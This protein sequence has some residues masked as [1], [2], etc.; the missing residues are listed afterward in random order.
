MKL[1]MKGIAMLGASS[2]LLALAQNLPQSPINNPGQAVTILCNIAGWIFTFLIV[3]SIIFV[4]Y[5]A[6]TYLT[7]GGDS[8]K[9][10]SANQMLIYAVV[11]I[12]VA[13][14]AKGVPTLVGGV[15]GSSFSAGCP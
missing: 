4:L 14:L 11:A 8:E 9:V 1:G 6:F 12:V 10:G 7:A 5:A 2:P 13:V 3:L 15:V